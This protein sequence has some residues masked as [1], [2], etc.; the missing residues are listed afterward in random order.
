MNSFSL[1]GYLRYV[2]FLVVT[3]FSLSLRAECQLSLD[4]DSTAHLFNATDNSLEFNIQVTNNAVG[5]DNYFVVFES[6]NSGDNSFTLLGQNHAEYLNYQVDSNEGIARTFEGNSASA[7]LNVSFLDENQIQEH[8]FDL[9]LERDEVESIWYADK[10]SDV[11]NIALYAGEPSGLYTLQASE[12]INLTKRVEAQLDL[13]VLESGQAFSSGS[14]Y[15]NVDLG[16]LRKGLKKSFDVAAISNAN[17]RLSVT[18]LHS[19]KLVHASGN[20]EINYTLSLSEGGVTLVNTES[21]NT[22]ELNDIAPTDASGRRYGAEVT[23][24]NVGK[25][26][27]GEYNDY[28]T[29]EISSLF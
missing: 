4:V 28:L 20:S 12:H 9:T 1:G 27:S 29:F 18:S 22:I 26:F 17:F 16:L 14:K 23:V 8:V 15:L 25:V 11:L 6:L 2:V 13:S 3:I 19:W 7:Y 21:V 24:G 10:Y 5:C